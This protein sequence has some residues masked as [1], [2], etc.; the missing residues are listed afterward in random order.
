MDYILEV[1]NLTKFYGDVLAV[2]NI[3]FSVKRG[4][5]FAFLGPNGAGKSTTIKIISTLLQKDKG[6]IT[7]NNKSDEEYIRNK[8]GIVFQENMLDD[9]LSAK[10]NLMFR[11]AF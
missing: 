5:F 7:L 4:N 9:E 6:Q 10:E 3:S 11:G 8:M 2:D 1:K